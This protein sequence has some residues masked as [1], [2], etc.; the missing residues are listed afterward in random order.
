MTAHVQERFCV[1]SVL[2]SFVPSSFHSLDVKRLS[3]LLS[4]DVG[5]CRYETIATAKVFERTDV[6]LTPGVLT[7]LESDLKALELC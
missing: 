1:S 4:T 7:V 2:L 5:Q 6:E 3:F